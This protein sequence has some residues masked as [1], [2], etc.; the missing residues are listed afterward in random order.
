M[1]FCQN[2]QHQHFKDTE[3]FNG[4]RTPFVGGF[5]LHQHV[6]CYYQYQQ[7]PDIGQ[8]CDESAV[9]T[10]DMY[11]VLVMH[12]KFVQS[13]SKRKSKEAGTGCVCVYT[14]TFS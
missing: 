8:I 14:H 2:R 13:L 4:G 12:Y 5:E 9:V 3:G 11:E 1:D 10:C 7:R 6:S